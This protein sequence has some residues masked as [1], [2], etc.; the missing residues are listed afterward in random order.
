MIY[1][2]LRDDHML[3]YINDKDIIIKFDLQY[4]KEKPT[5]NLMLY[6]KDQKIQLIYFQEKKFNMLIQEIVLQIV[7][8]NIV[9]KNIIELFLILLSLIK[10]IIKIKMKQ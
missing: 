3:N 2:L 8:E 6:G 4:F 5:I 1:K 7:K 10:E 9:T